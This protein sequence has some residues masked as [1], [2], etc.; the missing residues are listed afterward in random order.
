MNKNKLLKLYNDF[1]EGKFLLSSERKVYESGLKKL[2]LLAENSR[3][4]MYNKNGTFV[5]SPVVFD[6][7]L[8]P[9]FV[10]DTYTHLLDQANL[11]QEK[12]EQVFFAEAACAISCVTYIQAYSKNP[13]SNENIYVVTDKIYKTFSEMP[14]PDVSFKDITFKNELPA[15]FLF[16]NFNT[17]AYL[18]YYLTPITN[19]LELFVSIFGYNPKFKFEPSNILLYTKELPENIVI[20]DNKLKDFF[21]D[22]QSMEDEESKELFNTY[23]TFFYNL[24]LF[25]ACK[26]TIKYKTEEMNE[27]RVI[28]EK[29]LTIGKNIKKQKKLLETLPS[30]RFIDME[31]TL[32][33]YTKEYYLNNQSE[34]G[35]SKTPHWRT[36]HWHTYWTGKKDGTEERK[37]VLRFIPTLWVGNPDEIKEQTSFRVIK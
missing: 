10:A 4:K 2:K 25:L 37:K 30:Y 16:E 26:E 21:E 32:N 34:L 29:N 18:D 7:T 1:S 6:K 9:R 11:Y 12:R 15:L 36:A 35:E 23:S 24:L 28:A 14:L 33:N 17:V 19:K 31:V 20:G 27:Q 13:V 8:D 5:L 3:L 22:I